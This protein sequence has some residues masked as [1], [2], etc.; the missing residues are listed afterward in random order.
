MAAAPALLPS[1]NR[2]RSAFTSSGEAPLMSARSWSSQSSSVPSGWWRRHWRGA[3]A[4][5]TR[6]APTPF[7]D[8]KWH[9]PRCCF[10]RCWGC[11][12]P[13]RRQPTPGAAR[14]RWPCACRACGSAPRAGCNA[15]AT[16]ADSCGF[17]AP[18]TLGSL[19]SLGA[20]A[21]LGALRFGRHGRTAARGCRGCKAML[22][23]GSGLA[24]GVFKMISV[25]RQTRWIDKRQLWLAPAPQ[26]RA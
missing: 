17:A 12:C 7:R 25:F 20:L 15:L 4:R 22:G 24:G 23:H 19:G 6:P 9:G 10:P 13:P 11:V 1:N 3:P 18:G 16:L 14:R 21:T 5:L 8:A 26:R 2:R